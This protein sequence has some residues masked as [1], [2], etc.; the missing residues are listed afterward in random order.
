VEGLAGNAPVPTVPAQQEGT[1]GVNQILALNHLRKSY[2]GKVVLDDV[3]LV[4]LPG[5]KIGV[6]GAERDR[7]VHAAA[8]NGRPGTALSR[9][10]ARLR[11]GRSFHH[12]GYP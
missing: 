11:D 8:D 9:R 2:D 10:R 4:F 7:Q 6:V 12:R 5:A 1:P 3:T